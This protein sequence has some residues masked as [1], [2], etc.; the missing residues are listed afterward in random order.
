MYEIT[1][2]SDVRVLAT[3]CSLSEMG[4][5]EITQVQKALIANFACCR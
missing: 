4:K 1:Y 5:V 3:S 2:L